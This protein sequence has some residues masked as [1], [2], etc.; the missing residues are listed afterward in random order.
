MVVTLIGKRVNYIVYSIAGIAF[1]GWGIIGITI[2]IYAYKLGS[3]DFV[4]GVIGAVF[5]VTYLA[6][7]ALFGKFVDKYSKKIVMMAMLLYGIASVA[8]SFCS[9][10]VQIILVEPWRAAALSMTFVCLKFLVAEYA[11]KGEFDKSLMFYNLSWSSASI[12][13]P[14][15]G[16]LLISAFHLKAPFYLATFMAISALG[17]ATVLESNERKIS[18]ADNEK[19]VGERI[20]TATISLPLVSAFLYSFNESTLTYLF[21]IYASD[22]G[23]LAYTIGSI[24]LLM[25]LTRTISF[26][27]VTR[28]KVLTKEKMVMMSTLIYAISLPFIVTG[29]LAGFVLGFASTGIA[30]GL[31]FSASATLII[32]GKSKIRGRKTSIFES[33]IGI[34]SIAGPFLGGFLG[35]F[36]K[37][38]PYV[39]CSIVSAA[40]L[41]LQIYYHRRRFI[42]F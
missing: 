9:D 29:T 16:G 13:G 20:F 25:G 37:I 39:S 24:V 36:N 5:G 41:S 28:M 32:G 33:A 4:V 30:S 15:L 19:K 14:F 17:L 35:D 42:S 21:P 7:P 38:L 10:P 26:I 18:V 23:L 6:V 1:A 27:L 12:I 34:G 40:V 11:R 2:P 31:A 22:L 3:S 8:L